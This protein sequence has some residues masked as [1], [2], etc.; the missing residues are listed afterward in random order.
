M[1]WGTGLRAGLGGGV[2]GLGP[3]DLANPASPG[4]SPTH[5]PA[6]PASV[7]ATSMTR[8]RSHESN[9][10][11]RITRPLPGPETT[12]ARL[13]STGIHPTR[14]QPASKPSSLTINPGA[15]TVR[16]GS[17][18]AGTP[19]YLIISP[20]EGSDAAFLSPTSPGP[21]GSARSRTSSLSNRAAT[22]PTTPA[23][24]HASSGSVSA[25]ASDAAPKSPRTGG[26]IFHAIP[27]HWK[28]KLVNPS[29]PCFICKRAVGIR[30]AD[31][32]KSCRIVVHPDCKAHVSDGTC[33]LTQAHVK[34]LIGFLVDPPPN[35]AVDTHHPTLS[36]DFA[37]VHLLFHASYTYRPSNLGRH[38]VPNRPSQVTGSPPY[39]SSSPVLTLYLSGHTTNFGTIMLS[40]FI[41]LSPNWT[42]LYR[43]V[44]AIL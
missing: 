29:K 25:S 34:S 2:G 11:H 40:N 26:R 31:R 19:S 4:P 6:S 33:G 41:I 38:C 28:R 13:H 24:A 9:L 1:K 37:Q 7:A 12:P 14:T 39:R 30:G 42:S 32:C 44:L 8:S 21:P 22:T 16:R 43:L 23:L 20:D 5:A 15:G 27:H 35:S 17:G 10:P 36:P 3:G 18:E